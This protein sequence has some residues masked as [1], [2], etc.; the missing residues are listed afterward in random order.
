[1][2]TQGKYKVSRY[3]DNGQLKE[4]ANYKDGKQDGLYQRW[5]SNGQLKEEGNFK[6]GELDI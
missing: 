2:N 6:D 1:M 3:H 5:H 4:E